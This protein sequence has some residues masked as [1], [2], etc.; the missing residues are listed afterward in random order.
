MDL[1]GGCLLGNARVRRGLSA[2]FYDGRIGDGR[3]EDGRIDV[4]W[5][6]YGRRIDVG[7]TSRLIV[8]GNA[9]NIPR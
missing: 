3:I 6:L 8:G 1:Y 4:V 9:V 7:W 2:S 5:M